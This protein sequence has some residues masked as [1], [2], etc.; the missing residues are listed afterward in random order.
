MSN[1]TTSLKTVTPDGDSNTTHPMVIGK[2]DT[3]Q[4]LLLIV[5][6]FFLTLLVVAVTGKTAGYSVFYTAG[7]AKSAGAHADY[8]VD[9]DNSALAQDIFGL[10]A[11]SENA[12]A[13]TPC[14]NCPCCNICCSCSFC[15]SHKD[16]MKICA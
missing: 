15:Q 8:Q 6:S 13:D 16:W 3:Y 2:T 5:A 9:T 7:S 12:E 10:G 14:W 11:A 1:E 4:R